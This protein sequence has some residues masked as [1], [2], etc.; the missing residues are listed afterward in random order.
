VHTALSLGHDD[1]AHCRPIGAIADARFVPLGGS[2]HGTLEY[3]VS[4]AITPLR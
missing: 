4:G 2:T 1:T 3:D